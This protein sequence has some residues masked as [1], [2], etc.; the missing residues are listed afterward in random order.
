M[1][2]CTHVPN[3]TMNKNMRSGNRYLLQKMDFWASKT[4]LA[5]SGIVEKNF[6]LDFDDLTNH[7]GYVPKIL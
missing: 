1:N 6:F 2:F 5:L 7:K 3:S 4:L